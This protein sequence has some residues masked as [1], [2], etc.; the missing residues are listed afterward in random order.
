MWRNTPG[1]ETWFQF[2]NKHRFL[3]HKSL[4]DSLF[5]ESY[6]ILTIKE[7][8]QVDIFFKQ[9]LWKE[10]TPQRKKSHEK[11]RLKSSQLLI[12]TVI[13]GRTG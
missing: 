13:D 7:K 10:E 4:I 12:E 9:F 11:F 8:R 2:T 1:F 3:R 6:V 5:V